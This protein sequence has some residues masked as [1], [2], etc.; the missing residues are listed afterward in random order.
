[1]GVRRQ[2]V[3]G[4]SGVERGWRGEDGG[5]L[6]DRGIKAAMP[7]LIRSR[8]SS[9]AAAPNDNGS[10]AA[11]GTGSFSAVSHFDSSVTRGRGR[12]E[13]RDLR[14]GVTGALTD[15]KEGCEG[16]CRSDERSDLL[17]SLILERWVVGLVAR[18]NLECEPFQVW[19]L[20]E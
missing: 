6:G 11:S 8:R 19:R 4:A 14:K 15:V 10:S 17:F 9:R 18:T 5:G 2:P 12:V 13:L 16:L 3:S 7:A 1:M 20:L